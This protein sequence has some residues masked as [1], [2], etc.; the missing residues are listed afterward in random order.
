MWSPTVTLT[1][2]SAPSVGLSCPKRPAKRL[3]QKTGATNE[4]VRDGCIQPSREAH[5][6]EHEMCIS[7]FY[8]PSSTSKP[9]TGE[10]FAVVNTEGFVVELNVIKRSGHPQR[11][12]I[13]AEA[14]IQLGQHN[15]EVSQCLKQR[16]DCSTASP[17]GVRQPI[18]QPGSSIVC[19]RRSS[20]S[21]IPLK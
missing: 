14:H 12:L 13:C 3:V 15:V 17:G 19:V 6:H 9:V 2:C 4:D 18:V 5:E 10:A 20:P 8:S 16:V 1:L 7:R 11:Y 21:H